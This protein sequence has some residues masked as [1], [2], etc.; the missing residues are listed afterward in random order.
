MTVRKI[1][2]AVSAASGSR[3]GRGI[4]K[5][6]LMV[7]S[8]LVATPALALL[9]LIS[10]QGLF[11][12]ATQASS[13]STSRATYMD[14]FNIP[15]N[16]VDLI[17]DKDGTKSHT[18][19]NTTYRWTERKSNVGVYV[20]YS[21]MYDSSAQAY[22]QSSSAKIDT[23]TTVGAPYMAAGACPNYGK[24]I[25]FTKRDGSRSDMTRWKN[26]IHANVMPHS[27]TSCASRADPGAA[28]VA[29]SIEG[30]AMYAGYLTHCPYNV[31]VYRQDMVTDK[32]FDSTVCNFV[33]ESNPLRFLDTTQRQSTQP[34]TEYAFHG[35]GGH[36]GYDYK[37]QTSHVGCPPYNPPHVTKG[38]KDSSWITG[39][40][41]CSVLSRCT[42]HCWPYKSGGNCFR[43]LPAMFDMSTGE[44]RL[45]GYHTQ[46]FR[47]STCAELTTDDTNAFY[48]VRPMKTAAS[49]NMVYVTSHTRPDHET[50]CPPRE[51]LK[52]V[53]WGVV[54]KGKYCK[55][56]NARASLSNA[57]AEQCG[58]R[59]FM[60]SS[61]DGSSLSS[62]VRGYH[63]ATFV[64]TDCNMGE[65]C[66]ATA[67]GKCFFYSTVPECLIHSPT[68]MA[69]TSLS[70]V[71]PS[72]AIDPDSIAVLPEDKCVSVDCGAHGTCDV[73]TGKCVCEPGFTGE[74]C[75]KDDLCYQKT[76]SGHGQCKESDGSCECEG[77]Y[78]GDNCETV[79]KCYNEQ[80]SGHGTCNDETGH[81]E[82]QTCYTGAD[83]SQSVH[84]CCTTDSD[85]TGNK[86][87]STSTNECVCQAGWVGADCTEQDRCYNVECGEGKVCDA[88]TGACVC[89]EKCK[90]GPNCDQHKPECCGS[91][92]DCHQPQGYCK[93][94][95]STCICRPGFTGEN[96]GT[97]EDLCAGV[98]CKNGGTC[99]SATG[100]CQCDA[101]H[102]GKTCEITKEHCCIN[103]SDCN[104]HGTCNTSNNTCN[105]EAGF[106]G[107]NCS[108]SEGKCSGKT[109]LSGHCNPATGA[110]VCDPCHTGE[111]CE[112][113]VKD[114]CVVNDTCKFPNGVCTDSNRCECQS[115]WGQG[116]CSKPVDK[117]EDVSCNNGSS[118]DAD[119]GTCICPPGFGDEFC[120]TCSSKGCLNGGVCQPNGTCTC[121][122]G[123]EGPLCD[124]SGSCPGA[125]GQCQNGGACDPE[126]GQCICSEGFTGARC[127]EAGAPYTCS[128]W[129]KAPNLLDEALCDPDKDCYQVCCEVMKACAKIHRQSDSDDKW[130]QCYKDGM[131]ER[132]AS[133][134]YAREEASDYMAIYLAAGGVLLLLLAAGM[135]YG[136]RKRSTAAGGGGAMDFGVGEDGK[137]ATAAEEE[138]IEVNLDDFKSHPDDEVDIGNRL[139]STNWDA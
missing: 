115:G 2:Q 68:T 120:E 15:K 104:G 105:C 86:T 9:F 127:E 85:C 125:G 66:A 75:D 54:S 35:K 70:A 73:A 122:E 58:Q 63:W 114:C 39:P 61:A 111:R 76:C 116:D 133:C 40:F 119:S 90:T 100:L 32:E 83:C 94:D 93:M 31:N 23:K 47:S 55:P 106:A 1:L 78:K 59:L 26:E 87:C 136:L 49:S 130:S 92:D 36:K 42:T 81:C 62:Q 3:R 41:E 96:C 60:L 88:E 38:M 103:D 139:G 71:D 99:D 128:D 118:C 44:C 135:A 16:H 84:N 124:Q 51:P 89:E 132:Q 33:T 14:R 20:G 126:K 131:D 57:T 19:G 50:K 4:S 82:C 138:A 101:C 37:G 113:L 91:N 48:C 22:C 11:V 29:K 121:P 6:A 109:C 97:R 18:R 129:C 72:I 137:P 110:C 108:S 24:V 123:F 56:M 12:D 25:A 53:R 69:F 10:G 64:A 80:C 79:D 17:W 107:T 77:G 74:R 43:S 134:C 52:N 102:G 45:L 28:E 5:N 95:M 67:R 98:T 7:I 117:C 30:F 46:D 34:Y 27:T 21:E 65:S 112:T 13:T 8:F